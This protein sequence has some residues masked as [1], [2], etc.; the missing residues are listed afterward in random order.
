M[1]MIL[2]TGVILLCVLLVCPENGLGPVFWPK[3]V[4]Q[5]AVTSSPLHLYPLAFHD[6]T[7]F[8]SPRTLSK[9][10]VLIAHGG[11]D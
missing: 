5:R 2:N 1:S 7:R 3:S 10:S 6:I 8:L 9:A 4:P 11:E